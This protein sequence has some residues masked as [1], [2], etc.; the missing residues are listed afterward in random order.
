MIERMRIRRMVGAA[1]WGRLCLKAWVKCVLLVCSVCLNLAVDSTGRM[2][3]NQGA[4]S[5]DFVGFMR[6]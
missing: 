5:V 2:K 1:R 3:E 6:G 4:R